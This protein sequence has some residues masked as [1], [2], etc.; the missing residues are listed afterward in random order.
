M[1]KSLSPLF[2]WLAT[3]A[4]VGCAQ[5]PTELV[6][7][8]RARVASV[9]AEGAVYAS[10]EYGD[11]QAAVGRM[12]AEVVA[13]ADRFAMTRSYD[14]T[15]ELAG[16]AETA[17]DEVER[18]VAAEQERLRAEAIR[19]VAEAETTVTAARETL[20]GLSEE[21]TASLQD[22]LTAADASV[23][24]TN[25]ALAGDNPS[26]ALQAA[27]EAVQAA[28]G[29]TASL[30]AMQTEAEEA[31]EQDSGGLRAVRGGIDIP[32]MVYVDGQPLAAGAYTLRLGDGGVAPVGGESPAATRWVEFVSDEDGS[33]AGRALATAIPDAE[34]G[35]VAGGWVPRNQAYVAELLGGEYLRV[36]LNR[37]GVSYLVHAPTAAP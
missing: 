23:A 20:A 12:D 14:R 9:G 27:Q 33:V 25:E 35:E 28:N 15:T 30:M 32:R 21:E 22:A 36:W 18:A 8:A 19:L 37:G 11:A 26:A 10:A 7:A 4:V 2:L 13:Q 6:E 29:V 24:A 1:R 31:E 34:I 5:P 16:E 3:T 17:A